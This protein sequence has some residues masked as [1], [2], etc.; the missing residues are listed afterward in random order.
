[1]AALATARASGLGEGR[2]R[3]LL[4]V[5]LLL[6]AYILWPY[7]TLWRI[8][9]ALVADDRET[10]AALVDLGGVRAEILGDL[11]KESERPVRPMSDAFIDWLEQAIQHDGTDALERQ[12]TLDW[13]RER[14]LA[15]SPPG[16]GLRPALSRAF[17]D[18]PLHF[19]IR[20]GAL[21]E[22]PVLVRLS[23]TG[24]GWRITALD[25]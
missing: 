15:H 16:T 6:A 5:A 22:T 18:D 9:R 21:D 20:L 7:L 14:L 24:T 3:R 17:F 1:M 11:N 10:L 19:S 4:V 23:F 8:D 13:V 2:K 12:V 25:F